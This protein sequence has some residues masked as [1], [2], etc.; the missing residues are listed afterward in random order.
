M[1]REKH[2]KPEDSLLKEKYHEKLKEYK[3]NC[4]FKKCNFWENTLTE[5]NNSLDDPINFWRKWKN[6]DECHTST[7]QP[8]VTGEKWYDFFKNLHTETNNSKI[9]DNRDSIKSNVRYP[10]NNE[11]F[12]RKE[13]EKVIKRLKNEKAEGNDSISNEMIKNSPK[14]IFDLLFNF[15]N[16]CLEKSFI[17]K[18]W[19]LDLINPIHKEGNKDDPNNYRGLCISSVLLKIICSILNNRILL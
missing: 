1:G 13:F 2:K 7:S 12:T 17:P 10:E 8:N 11:P 18:S 9:E 6:L 3:K 4:K 15:I 14:I 16:T 19:C 5:I